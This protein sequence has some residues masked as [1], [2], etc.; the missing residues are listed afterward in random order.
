MDSTPFQVRPVDE[1]GLE[2]II[3]VITFQYADNRSV[4]FIKTKSLAF[5]NL[6]NIFAT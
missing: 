2:N 3:T 4:D 1:P 5:L 6:N